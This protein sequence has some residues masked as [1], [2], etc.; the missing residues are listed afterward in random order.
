VVCGQGHPATTTLR[1]LLA[2]LLLL[3]SVSCA[4]YVKGTSSTATTS[5]VAT[6]TDDQSK[7]EFDALVT[8]AVA[9]ARD[10]GFGPETQA[11]LAAIVRALGEQL[12]ALASALGDQ[13]RAQLLSTRDAMLDQTLDKGVVRLREELL[14]AE[15]RQLLQQ[16]LSEIVASAGPLR[17]Q[18]VGAP[19]RDD[20]DALL[21]D[22]G[23]RIDAAVQA[24][25]AKI[26]ADANAE[27]AKYKLMLAAS[28]VVLLIVV[29]GAIYVVRSHRK[30]IDSL[31]A[32]RK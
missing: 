17:E 13:L 10:Q 27:I 21:A 5:A 31:L 11:R 8:S 1:A 4:S 14:G 9:A 30:I 32:S 18:L 19:L 24:S 6:L 29:V 26:Q 2:A 12:K 16:L 20:A 15:T 23:P 3:C 22:I 7:K 25:L 28:G